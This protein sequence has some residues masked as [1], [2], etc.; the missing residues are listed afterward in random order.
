MGPWPR[1]AT[2]RA[3]LLTA[4]GASRSFAE[5][6]KGE[7]L[8]PE[9]R[10]YADPA[11][12]LAVSR[13]TDP[14][15]SCGLPASYQRMIGRGNFLLFW[16]D[17]TGSPQAWRMDLKSGEMRLL[18]AARRAGRPVPHPASGRALLQLLRRP[19]AACDLA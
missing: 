11:T 2:R 4:A 12:E 13:L 5:E 16:S 17:R 15:S 3:F 8:P 6:K 18:T 1:V 7:L 10:R 9:W 14:A 19:R